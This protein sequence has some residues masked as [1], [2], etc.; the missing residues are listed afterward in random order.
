MMK[1]LAGAAA[2]MLGAIFPNAVAAVDLPA[3]FAGTWR[4]AN[5]SDNQCRKEDLKG[6][7]SAEG[8][9]SVK[10]GL[11]VHYESECRIMS[12]K[13][14]GQSNPITVEA[15]FACRGEGMRWRAREIWHVETIDGKRV[16]A[17]TQAGRGRRAKFNNIVSTLI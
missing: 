5:P 7:D 3:E 4:L 10:P 13:Q 1:S 6:G 16:L 11:V 2:V 15:S 14:T 12:V 9:I 17:V 8:H